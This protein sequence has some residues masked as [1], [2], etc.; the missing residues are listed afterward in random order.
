MSHEEHHDEERLRALF[1]ETAVDASDEALH[2]MARR[3]ALIPEQAVAPWWRRV[4]PWA[5]I[6]VAAAAALAIVVDRDAPSVAP[7]APVASHGGSPPA[8][9][10]APD[11]VPETVR[12]ETVPYDTVQ[13]EEVEAWLALADDETLAEDDVSSD[14]LAALGAGSGELD[15]LDM[16]FGT[17]DDAGLELLIDAYATTMEL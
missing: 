14:P 13:D 2:R 16:L 12:D 6:A 15:A 4:A 5:A 3:A 9:D 11:V 7:N 10:V 17:D 1:D 8:P